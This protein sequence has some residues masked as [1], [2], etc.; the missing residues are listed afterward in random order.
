MLFR[1]KDAKSGSA[2]KKNFLKIFLTPISSQMKESLAALQK[3]K[4]LLKPY[5]C[6]EKSLLLR[7][8]DLIPVDAFF[9]L[10]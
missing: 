1:I 5:D 10:C 6:G 7:Q 4:L 3:S 2:A 8:A 9:R